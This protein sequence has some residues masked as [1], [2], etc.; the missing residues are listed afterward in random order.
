MLDRVKRYEPCHGEVIALFSSLAKVVHKLEKD[1]MEH[2]KGSFSVLETVKVK[3]EQIL[4]TLSAYCLK[5]IDSM[6]PSVCPGIDHRVLL[7]L[8]Q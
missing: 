1:E 2:T 8:V 6:L 5:Q 7:Y 4:K 3:T